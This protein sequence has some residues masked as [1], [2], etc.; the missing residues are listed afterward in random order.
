MKKSEKSNNNDQ[1]GEPDNTEK[2]KCIACHKVRHIKKNCPERKKAKEAQNNQNTQ[3]AE[4]AVVE[5]GY[6]S[7]EAL[8]II[9]NKMCEE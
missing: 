7:V 4:A 2:R 8:T 6:E 3:N 9:D 1:K 5:E